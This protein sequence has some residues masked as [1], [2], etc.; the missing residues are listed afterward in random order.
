MERWTARR[1]VRLGCAVN[2]WPF[3]AQILSVCLGQLN[4]LGHPQPLSRAGH[5]LLAVSFDAL[6]DDEVVEILTKSGRDL[7]AAAAG[8]DRLRAGRVTQHDEYAVLV[9]A[10]RKSD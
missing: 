9:G 4:G 2:G 3:L 10:D 6:L 1:P 8:R 7:D 5:E